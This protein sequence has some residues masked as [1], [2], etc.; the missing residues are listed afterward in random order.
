[1]SF[2]RDK[3]YFY[4]GQPVAPRSVERAA[5]YLDRVDAVLGQSE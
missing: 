4:A 5:Q 3:A 1:M 2:G